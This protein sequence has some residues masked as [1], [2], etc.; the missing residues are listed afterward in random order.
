MP[1]TPG[2]G[3]SGA[4]YHKYNNSR[5]NN[6]NRKIRKKQNITLD[7]VEEDKSVDHTENEDLVY[8]LKET[9]KNVSEDQISHDVLQ[10]WKRTW[11][12]RKET[13]AENFH[14]VDK[15]V[16]EWPLYFHKDGYLLV[17]I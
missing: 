4:L 15:I 8:N 16:E 13:L 17:C 5:R 10:I 3:Y 7:E 12:I 2:K 1:R 9:L 6:P 14:D 11:S